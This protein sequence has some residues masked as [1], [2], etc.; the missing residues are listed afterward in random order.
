[1]DLDDLPSESASALAEAGD[2]SAN[3]NAVA[4]LIGEIS[5]SHPSASNAVSASSPVWS[6]DDKQLVVDHAAATSG[7]ADHAGA[8][9]LDT[10][11]MVPSEAKPASSTH[12]TLLS[13]HLSATAT[14]NRMV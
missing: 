4:D 14:S 10:S 11:S 5:P 13:N 7:V 6:D 1:M 12:S 2:T 8:A 9:T 3:E